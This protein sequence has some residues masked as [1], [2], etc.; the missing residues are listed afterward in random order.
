M[1]GAATATVLRPGRQHLQGFL[2]LSA[3]DDCVSAKQ[4]SVH[5]RLTQAPALRGCFS[6]G[7]VG[8]PTPPLYRATLVI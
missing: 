7:A 6:A 3:G 1:W 5:P 2:S 4:Q 8:E